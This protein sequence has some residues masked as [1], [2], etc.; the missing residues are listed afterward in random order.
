[1]SHGPATGNT[2]ALSFDDGPHPEHT[3]RLLDT[4]RDQGVQATFF[5][6]GEHALR[7]PDL[8]RRMAAEGHIVGNH[9]YRPHQGSPLPMSFGQVK[10]EIQETGAVLT[11]ILG[12]APVPLFRPPFGRLTARVFWWLVKS[13]YTTVLWN[14][15]PKDYACKCSEDVRAWFA[16]R[17]MSA[18]DVVLMHDNHPH[19]ASI[20]PDLISSVREQGLKFVPLSDWVFP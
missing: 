2:L 5:V 1:L 14:V 17:P 3:P 10:D 11:R 13:G 15:D 4:L 7:H 12:H 9:T 8:I 6:I 18:G 19:A 20:M 16:G